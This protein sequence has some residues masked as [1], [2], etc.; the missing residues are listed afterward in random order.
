M[1]QTRYSI[2]HTLLILLFVVEGV[3]FAGPAEEA[4]QAVGEAVQT[5]G[6]ASASAM[7]GIAASGQV[8][9][10]VM[11][12]PL[13][14]AGVVLGA[15]GNASQQAAS[16][17]AK[18]ADIPIGTPLPVANENLSIVSPDKALLPK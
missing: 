9:S 14:A 1:N 18:I 11:A 5:S 2:K 15:S 8:T 7:H 12:V 16:A 4:N 17:L 10:A 3:A 13:S 6:H